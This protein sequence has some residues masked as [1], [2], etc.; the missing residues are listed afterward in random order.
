MDVVEISVL[1]LPRIDGLC[2]SEEGDATFSKD[3]RQ[4][5]Q[6]LELELLDV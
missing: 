3:P 6:E 5:F 4:S 1:I 2:G